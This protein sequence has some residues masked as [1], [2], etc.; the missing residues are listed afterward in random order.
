MSIVVGGTDVPTLEVSPFDATT[1]AAVTV[2]AP[3]ETETT[4]NT[5]SA[6]DTPTTGTQT[7]TAE[8][9]AYGQAGNWVL[10]WEVTGTGA[11]VAEQKVTV[12]RAMVGLPAITVD[13]ATDIGKVRLLAVDLDEVTPLFEDAQITALLGMCGDR[14]RRAAAMALDTIASSEALISKRIRTL[15]LQTDGPA[16]AKALRDHAQRLREEDDQLD[17]DGAW[18]LEIVE[19]DPWAAYRTTGG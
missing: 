5:T 2:Q 11:G 14:V 4:P 8:A 17:D 9:V 1:A 13:P 18:G 19:F 3:D 12:T 10:R 15:D 6:D 7:W 16:V